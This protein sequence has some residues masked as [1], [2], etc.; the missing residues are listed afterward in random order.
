MFIPLIGLICQFDPKGLT[1]VVLGLGLRKRT[2]LRLWFNN[3]SK[4]N[5][6]SRKSLE[7]EGGHFDVS[8]G[9]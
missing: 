9:S 2:K 5:S 1:K 8:P 4:H 7:R 3:M 6:I